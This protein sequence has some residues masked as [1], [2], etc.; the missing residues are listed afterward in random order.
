MLEILYNFVPKLIICDEVD[1]LFLIIKKV[2]YF[3]SVLSRAL[4]KF[5]WAAD[6]CS[7]PLPSLLTKQLERFVYTWR[8][9]SENLLKFAFYKDIYLQL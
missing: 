7:P 6:L 3:Y 1:Y 9:Q 2:N 8:S 5:H 4:P